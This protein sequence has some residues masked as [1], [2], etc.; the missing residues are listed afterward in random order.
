MRLHVWVEPYQQAF[1]TVRPSDMERLFFVSSYSE[2]DPDSRAPK[3][4]GYQR[5]PMSARLPGIARYFLQSDKTHR[6]TAIEVSVRLRDEEE[7]DEF[8]A[9]LNLG[10]IDEIHR[11]WHKAV[12]SVVDGQH[13]Y[14]GLVKAYHEAEAAG[15]EFNPP[16]PVMLEFD[17]TYEDEAELFDTINTTQRKLP[18]ALI[19]VTKGDITE[20][21]SNSWAQQVREISFALTRDTDSVFYDAEAG[22][23]TIVN[24]TGARDPNKP[25]TYEGLRRSTANMFT[26]QVIDRLNAKQ[27]DSVDVAKFYWA[28]V[29]ESCSAAWE[30]HGRIVP[31]PQTGEMIEEPVNY[32]IKELVGIAS[33]AKLGADI[34]R[35]ALEHTDFEERMTDLVSKLSEVDWEKRPNNPWMRSQAGFAGQKELYTMLYNLVYLD[36]KPGELA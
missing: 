24:M 2:A 19:E 7:I 16:S 21:D 25:I 3:H 20:A 22:D 10:K 15:S 33:L 34:I 13:R 5:E 30:D 36:E 17:L 18:K 12:V 8:V 27:R 9:M 32:R 28:L 1:A 35:S 4:H 11:R 31:D 6:R 14:R 29:A 26:A 23:K